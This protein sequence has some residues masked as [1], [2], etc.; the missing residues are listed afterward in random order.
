VSLEF[1]R[2]R[3]HS[4]LV[5]AAL[6]LCLTWCLI[7]F[8]WQEPIHSLHGVQQPPPLPKAGL[9]LR[10]TVSGLAVYVPVQGNQCWD[11]PLPCTPYFDETLRLRNESSLRWGFLADGRSVELQKF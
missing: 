6:L 8:G 1:H 7:S 3:S 2:A 9:V 11:A 10:H 5:L 4:R